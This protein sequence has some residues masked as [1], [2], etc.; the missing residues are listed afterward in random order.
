MLNGRPLLTQL[1][2]NERQPIFGDLLRGC[3]VKTG[4]Q[5]EV[6]THNLDFQLP[7][8]DP[9]DH[10]LNVCRRVSEMRPGSPGIPPDRAV[11]PLMTG[12][13]RP[14]E[15][16][17]LT[18]EGLTPFTDEGI[19][20]SGTLRGPVSGKVIPGN[21]CGPCECLS[22]QGDIRSRRLLHRARS[23]RQRRARQL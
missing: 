2:K 19:V 10:V 17:T 7:D 21:R 9:T 22:R 11:D 14:G 15:S 12:K 1:H 4:G 5:A 23:I 16:N 20:L 8:E 18:G 13:S 6:S 3:I